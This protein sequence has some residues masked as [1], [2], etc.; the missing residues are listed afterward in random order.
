MNLMNL[1]S[2]LTFEIFAVFGFFY[3]FVYIT[4]KFSH[5]LISDISEVENKSCIS[6]LF[7]IAISWPLAWGA[8]GLISAWCYYL[9]FNMQVA[10]LV[11]GILGLIMGL[12]AHKNHKFVDKALFM[13]FKWRD[14]KLILALILFFSA[15]ALHYTFLIFS[16]YDHDETAVYGFVTKLISNGWV[17][18]DHIF[19]NSIHDRPVLVQSLDAQLFSFFK[20]PILVR[21]SRLVNLGFIS[22][23]FI[24]YLCLFFE[25]N[26][27]MI[28]GA[29]CMLV[30][31]EFCQFLGMSLKVD[32]TLMMF[33][34][35]GLLITSLAILSF[36]KNKFRTSQQNLIWLLLC[37]ELLFLATASSNFSGIYAT[38]FTYVF[39]IF[40]LFLGRKQ[41]FRPWLLFFISTILILLG[42]PTYLI[43]LFEYGN[44]LFPFQSPIGTAVTT[45]QDWKGMYNL[46]D[47][48]FPLLQIYMLVHLALGLENMDWPLH[49]HDKGISMNWLSPLLLTMFIVPVF[50]R[51]NKQLAV[52]CA[53]FFAQFCLWSF[54]L[55]YS[56]ALLAT[57]ALAVLM[58]T[59]VACMSNHSLSKT[60]S[61]LRLTIMT[62]LLFVAVWFPVKLIYGHGL[63]HF[64]SIPIKAVSRSSHHYFKVRMLKENYSEDEP[65]TS[66][67][68]S[69]IDLV[70]LAATKPT[71][72]AACP[73][74][75]VVHILFKDGLFRDA[76]VSIL[77]N[78]S[79]KN[80]TF[81]L[82]NQKFAQSKIPAFE[83]VVDTSKLKK[84]FESGD[85]NWILLGA[86]CGT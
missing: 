71:I 5:H 24:A 83:K 26:F 17:Y 38:I 30:T 79:A 2:N 10:I 55:H 48:P 84:C 41:L 54:G 76:D 34:F 18:A 12:W 78:M 70:L 45:I 40:L 28:L 14:P 8:R 42:T 65:P 23:A 68:L 72:Y 64:L 7:L 61:F 25:L 81:Y 44:P 36:I 32:A 63:K 82:I 37:A 11:S 19:Y 85:K 27:W 80:N 51:K 21:L 39:I 33:E 20:D 53:I 66:Q 52:L 57:N 74:G 86:D 47:I 1:L 73:S 31:P 59:Y 13:N 35:A 67:E 16:W 22:L 43:H 9:N 4:Y 62:G 15:L 56:R 3:F 69:Q 50:V 77:E 6:K 46:K 75:R 60:F 58:A 29:T 49:A